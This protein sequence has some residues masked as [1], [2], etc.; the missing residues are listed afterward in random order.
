M[1][2]K[3]KYGFGYLL[4]MGK[5]NPKINLSQASPYDTCIMHLSPEKTVFGNV[6]TSASLGCAAACLNTAGRGKMRT[7]QAARLARTKLWFQDRNSFL[8][9]L[10]SEIQRHIKR[11]YKSGKIP[12]F[13]LNGTSDIIWE[14]AFPSLFTMYPKAQFY[15][16]TKHVFRCMASHKL[17]PNYHLTFSRSETNDK[18]C[19]RVLRSGKC[20]VAVVFQDKHYPPTWAG[21][22]VY[23]M[24]GSDLRFLDPPGVGALYAKGKARHDTSGFVLP[25]K[26][27]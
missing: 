22:K 19:R 24:D 6:C 17:P 10:V 9:L 16:Y 13:R 14:K 21:K 25:T 2:W 4:T 12:A 20:N 15:D 3:K 27:V 7:T 23:S 5:A 1:D 8:I 18:D 11:C 26:G